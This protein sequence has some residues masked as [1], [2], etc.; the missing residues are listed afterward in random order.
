M[1]IALYDWP[2]LLKKRLFFR[3]LGR[4][5][6]VL[7]LPE[8]VQGLVCGARAWPGA[9]DVAAV[10][11]RSDQI[12]C[13]DWRY[14]ALPRLYLLTGSNERAVSDNV[15]TWRGGNVVTSS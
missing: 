4:L 14:R 11:L 13:P 9:S 1:C 15:T 12:V 10:E 6:S 7:K 8:I 2:V 5:G 3:C